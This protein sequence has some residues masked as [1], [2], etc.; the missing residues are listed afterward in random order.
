LD[1]QFSTRM[2]NRV[3]AKMFPSMKTENRRPS[4]HRVPWCYQTGTLKKGTLTPVKL[5][6]NI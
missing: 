2:P 1:L 5:D 4:N 6:A 3:T